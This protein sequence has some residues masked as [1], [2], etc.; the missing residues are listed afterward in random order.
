MCHC[1]FAS[2]FPWGSTSIFSQASFLFN[3]F[4]RHIPNSQVVKRPDRGIKSSF[5]G[6]DFGHQSH[7][8]PI[9]HLFSFPIFFSFPQVVKVMNKI[10]LW[11]LFYLLLSKMCHLMCIGNSSKSFY[12]YVDR[13]CHA[14]QVTSVNATQTIIDNPKNLACL[15][16]YQFIE[17]KMFLVICC[18]ICVWPKFSICSMMH[19]HVL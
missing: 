17:P 19:T 15:L 8:M 13:H 9:T 6:G 10:S 2:V 18:K 4:R 12:V 3:I 16:C 14:H 1:L 7:A 5:F 11:A